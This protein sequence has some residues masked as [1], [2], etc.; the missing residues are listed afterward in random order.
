MEAKELNLI[1][2]VGNQDPDTGS[3]AERIKKTAED[4]GSLL[5][6][7]GLWVFSSQ[8]TLDTADHLNTCLGKKSL[9]PGNVAINGYLFED[10]LGEDGSEEAWRA[11]LSTRSHIA[12]FRSQH[13]LSQRHKIGLVM[14]THGDIVEQIPIALGKKGYEGKTNTDYVGINYLTV[15]VDENGYLLE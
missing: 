7:A 14:V 13:R 3:N 8:D 15:K 2:T 1:A 6:P 9:N 10:A 4:I 12:F 11:D 5:E